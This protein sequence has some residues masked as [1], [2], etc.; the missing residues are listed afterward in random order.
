MF[1]ELREADRIR[2]RCHTGY[3]FSADALLAELTDGIGA[4]M[5]NTVRSIE[6][7][8][9]LMKHLARHLEFQN[10]SLAQKF[11]AKA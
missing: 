2:F 3:A 10:G 1:R 8:V 4:S 6:E 11:S 5:W 9:M 7:S